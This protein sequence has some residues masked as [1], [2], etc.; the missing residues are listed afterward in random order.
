M[1]AI[2]TGGAGFIGSVLVDELIDRGSE[3]AVIDNLSTGRLEN[4][5]HH[6]GNDLF[7]FTE[8]DIMDYDRMVTE[9]AGYD[10]V[11]H[12]AANADIR[13]GLLKPR[14]DL[15]QNTIATFNVLD[16]ARLNDINKILF[17][18]S[19]AI[20]GEPTVFPTPEDYAPVQ[21]S[22]YGASKLAGEALIQAYCEGYGFRSWM[23][24]FVSV[25]GNRHPH[26]VTY[27]FVHKLKKNP[28]EL[29]ILGNGKQKKSFIDVDDIISGIMFAFENAKDNVNIFNLGTD[30]YIV[31]DRIAEIVTDEMG[32]SNVEYRH[33]GGERGWV[34]D[35]P[36]VYLSIE[37]MKQLGWEPKIGIEESIRKTVRYIVE[38]GI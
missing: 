32:L 17:S 14:R 11:F 15:E 7:K 35:A 3:V 6:K 21:T 19:S 24:R 10:A 28:K 9:F 30:E 38:H 12:I 1:R 22:L 13:K 26:G 20:Y 36:F 33:T 37:R 25:I 4:I 31:V 18:S 8:A 27:D 29:E 23:F 34:G 2:V 16:A 5:N